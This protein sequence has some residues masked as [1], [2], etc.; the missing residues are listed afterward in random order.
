MDVLTDFPERLKPGVIVYIGSQHQPMKLRSC[1]WH[2]QALLVGFED[3]L[4][5]ERVGGFRNQIVHVRADDRPAL[6]EGDYYHHQIL[7]LRVTT[8]VGERLGLVTEILETGANDVY[9]V[10]QQDG[11]DILLPAVD[12]VILGIDLEKGEMRVHL[13][14]GILPNSSP[15]WG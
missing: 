14:P 15:D 6:P 10:A 5:R 9:V 13:M 4:D 7:G 11:P 1:R 2:N 12:E 8:E 3:I